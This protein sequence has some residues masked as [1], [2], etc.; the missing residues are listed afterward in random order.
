MATDTLWFSPTDV[1]TGENAL[2][3]SHPSVKHPAV[4]ITAKLPGDLNWIYLAL[5]VAPYHEI[6]AI[7]VCYQLSNTGT[8]ISQVRLVEMQTPDVAIVRHD[9]IHVKDQLTIDPTCYRS[10]FGKAYRSD[11]AINLALRLNFGNVADKIILGAIGVEVNQ[12]LTWNSLFGRPELRGPISFN[13]GKALRADTGFVHYGRNALD[14]DFHTNPY[15]PGPWDAT[16]ST[17]AAWRILSNQAMLPY[18]DFQWSSRFLPYNPYGTYATQLSIIRTSKASPPGSVYA[19][20]AG[21]MYWDA[22]QINEEEHFVHFGG[23]SDPAHRVV[24]VSDPNR[25]LMKFDTEDFF[26]KYLVPLIDNVYRKYPH[27]TGTPA[28]FV[29]N[30]PGL[31]A[32][33]SNLDDTEGW[34]HFSTDEAWFAGWQQVFRR[35]KSKYPNLKIMA[36]WIPDNR[37]DEADRVLELIDHIMFE[38]FYGGPALKWHLAYAYRAQQMGKG[39]TFAALPTEHP[40]VPSGSEPT[41]DDYSRKPNDN[42]EYRQAYFCAFLLTWGESSHWG[43]RWYVDPDVSSKI[44]DLEGLRKWFGVPA[45]GENGTNMWEMRPDLWTRNFVNGKVF[46]NVS[47][48]G[49]K[50]YTIP[51]SE[52]VDENG[53]PVQS[54]TLESQQGEF[55]FRQG[56]PKSGSP[57]NVPYWRQ[58]PNLWRG[59]QSYPYSISCDAIVSSLNCGVGESNENWV[60]HSEDLAADAW[61]KEGATAVTKPTGGIWNGIQMYDLENDSSDPFATGV[62]HVINYGFPLASRHVTIM[63]YVQQLDP[64]IQVVY[65]VIDGIN[66]WTYHQLKW[67][68]YPQLIA[69]SIRVPDTF[70]ETSCAIAIGGAPY[71]TKGKFRMGAVRVLISSVPDNPAIGEYIR[72]TGTPLTRGQ[73]AGVGLP[74]S[75]LS[76][77]GYLSPAGRP[78]L[79]LL[80]STQIVGLASGGGT[81]A[82]R[83]EVT[84]LLGVSDIG[85]QYFDVTLGMPVWW[86]GTQWTKADGTPAV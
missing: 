79:P 68:D 84:P 76:L 56:P 38:N 31:R 49:A 65:L 75:L 14:W 22:D 63:C 83:D 10:E 54:I 74:V 47:D 12:V 20:F 50:T 59:D 48:A 62:R 72:T 32:Y 4:E 13:P 71:G 73:G 1:V 70:T 80:N 66:T 58:L 52:A 26:N 28:I 67:G 15:T 77:S 82:E 51:L 86:S 23:T 33:W 35:I 69:S 46:L 36:N 78:Q 3:V 43:G 21:T 40:N 19:Q 24:W 11:G 37:D 44:H 18:D 25:F 55:V 9:D 41:L 2:T 27:A 53:D 5:E 85:Y 16:R 8:F 57:A 29:D 34:D 7:R 45:A 6:N 42:Y 39:I 64:V 61:S 17:T 60:S 30:C 81:K